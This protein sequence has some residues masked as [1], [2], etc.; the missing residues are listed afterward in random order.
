MQQN[1]TTITSTND[2]DDDEKFEVSKQEMLD[3]CGMHYFLQP[4]LN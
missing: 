2:D 1:A 3:A 4:M